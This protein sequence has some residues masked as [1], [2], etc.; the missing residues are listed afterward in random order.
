MYTNRVAKFLFRPRVKI[1]KFPKTYWFILFNFNYIHKIYTKTT[2]S[3]LTFL[4]S[5]MQ[6]NHTK[7]LSHSIHQQH[8]LSDSIGFHCGEFPSVKSFSLSL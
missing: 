3:S 4:S 7:Q 1:Q 2:A 5:R 6:Q 8:Q